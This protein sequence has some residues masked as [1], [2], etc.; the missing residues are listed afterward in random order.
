MGGMDQPDLELLDAVLTMTIATG[1]GDEEAVELFL[2]GHDPAHLAVAGA[3]VIWRMATALG[4]KVTPP[5][6]ALQVIHAFAQA[7]RETGDELGDAG[8][9]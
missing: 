5:R 4:Q 7:L 3:D 9:T 6:S 1:A 8:S 2:R